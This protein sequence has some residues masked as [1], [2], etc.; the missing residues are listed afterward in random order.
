MR[1]VLMAPSDPPARPAPAPAPPPADSAGPHD[2]TKLT[3]SPAVVAA[4]GAVL[5]LTRAARSFALYDPANKVVR[6][7]IGDYRDKARRFLDTHGALALD[8]H[9]FELLLGHDV[10]YV[11]KDRER[12]LA[13]RLFR[14]G[15]RRLSIAPAATWEDL[16]RLLEILSIRFTGV[17]QQEDDL[18]TLLRK[19]GFEGITIHAIEGFVPEEE[20]AEPAAAYAERDA[21]LPR[22]DPP[23]QWDALPAFS[24]SAPLRHRTVPEE[25][26]APLREE[27]GP[28]ALAP[29]ALRAVVD[30][31]ATAATDADRQEALAFAS[32]VRDFLLVEGR[33][34]VLARLAAAVGQPGFVEPKAVR[35]LVLAQPPETI[36]VPEALAA[37]LDAT[38]DDPLTLPLELL[39]GEGDGSRAPFLRR[40]AARAARGSIEPL[41]ARLAAAQ[42]PAAAALLQVVAEIDPEAALAIALA[43]A[44]GGDPA[45]EIALLSLLERVAPAPAHLPAL[46]GLLS[47]G[48]SETARTRAATLLAARAGA[49]ALPLLRAHVEG[50]TD[51]GAGEAEACGRAMAEAA[52]RPAL[53]A[54][55]E[56]LHPKAGGL[57]GRIVG[58]TV[59][60]AR[61]H[62][63]LAGLERLGGA[64]AEALLRLLA[65]KGDASVRARAA[66]AVARRHGPP[67]PGGEH[68]G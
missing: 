16:L 36:E 60:L 39:A 31:I 23:R 7:L 1:L 46:R 45:V 32:E 17:R 22:F 58:P 44:H 56:W 20:M 26:L 3:G 18:V 62:A 40:L 64:E 38:G 47:S 8:V 49:R 52:A 68:R 67:R 2:E 30:L 41:R 14:D 24:E 43:R 15:V 33:A 42:G 54:F 11:E 28:A 59:H 4:N 53:D 61:Q 55:T 51:L 50:R 63:A 35:A 29:L 48:Q 9:P 13:F 5:A 21:A 37:M 27:E 12:S 10:V 57:L 65:E 25:Q 34:D 66:D 6:Q 19:A